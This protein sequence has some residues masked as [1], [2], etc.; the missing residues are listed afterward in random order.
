MFSQTAP[1]IQ[2]GRISF[3]AHLRLVPDGS[4]TD[5]SSIEAFMTIN[6]VDFIYMTGLIVS[7]AFVISLARLM[8]S[9]LARDLFARLY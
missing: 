4:L 2:N 3:G 8:D 6:H 7:F 9:E 1:S 5:M